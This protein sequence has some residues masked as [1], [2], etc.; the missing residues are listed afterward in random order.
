MN[1]LVRIARWTGI[2][3]GRAFFLALRT[4]TKIALTGSAIYLV[5]RT[6]TLVGDGRAVDFAM[7]L[8]L[9]IGLAAA[10][11]VQALLAP[12]LTGSDMHIAET[13]KPVRIV[14]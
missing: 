11:L 14:N 7:A 2:A 13:P 4:A 1:S 6:M 5:Y 12:R 3:L 8:A 10:L 9:F